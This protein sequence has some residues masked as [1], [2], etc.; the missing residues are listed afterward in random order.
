MAV[1]LAQLSADTGEVYD[2]LD[3]GSTAATA[4]LSRSQ[5]HV[6]LFSSTTTGYD[7]VIRPLTDAM[8]VNQVMGGVDSV[9]K[10]V[11]SLSVGAK[12]MKNMQSF[13]MDEVRKACIHKGVSFDG[14][15]VIFEASQ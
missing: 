8:I 4:I 14:L 11:G 13:F 7:A 2:A 3:G 12:D 15:R 10:T 5:E 6:K 9:N 1:T